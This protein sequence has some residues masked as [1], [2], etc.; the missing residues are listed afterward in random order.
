ML[1]IVV[2]IVIVV[3]ITVVNA[4]VLYTV[5]A[6]YG[7]PVLLPRP[8]RG[9]TGGVSLEDLTDRES[10]LVHR[11]R[12]YVLHLGGLMKVSVAVRVMQV[13]SRM[14]HQRGS[15]SRV[16][17]GCR[18]EDRGRCRKTD[19]CHGRRWRERQSRHQRNADWGPMQPLYGRV[20]DLVAETVLSTRW[21]VRDLGFPGRV[22]RQQV[23]RVTGLVSGHYDVLDRFGATWRG[24]GG[25]RGSR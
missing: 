25:R 16:P 17:A 21:I 9:R 3:M 8:R 23:L 20:D 24:G 1:Q 4:V 11:I 18:V 6:R 22:P 5:R 2:V 19:N 7:S 10:M 14:R 13:L 15:F 12:R